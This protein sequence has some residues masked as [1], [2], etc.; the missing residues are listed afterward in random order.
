MVAESRYQPT[1]WVQWDSASSRPTTY[2]FGL[3]LSPYAP[4][5]PLKRAL[6]KNRSVRCGEVAR[7][8]ERTRGCWSTNIA[9]L[10][11]HGDSFDSDPRS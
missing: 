1:V 2:Y 4:N 5:I 10:R 6:A 11:L 3:L 9:I 8:E 7:D